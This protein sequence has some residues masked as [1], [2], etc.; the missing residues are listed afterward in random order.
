L[1]NNATSETG[2]G[3]AV[4]LFGT[5]MLIEDCTFRNNSAGA[6]GAITLYQ[7]LVE[8]RRCVFEGNSAR[9]GGG[10]IYVS[11]ASPVIEE[12]LFIANRAST[13][14]G[15]IQFR[16]A[17]LSPVTRCTF[18]GNEAAQGGAMGLVEGSLNVPVLDACL[19]VFQDGGAS[20]FDSSQ[21]SYIIECTN[22]FGNEG[23]D[24]IGDFAFWSTLNGNLS[25]YPLFCDPDQ[26]DYSLAANSPCLP[27]NHP[28]GWNCGLIGALGQ[29]CGPVA[30]T[31]QTW[32][33]VKARYRR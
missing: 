9:W 4:R 29:G 7:G 19:I 1:E 28:A 3:G 33:R 30:L 20:L 17:Y 23:G 14:G 21:G 25:V 15:A 31:P 2:I 10:A 5:T 8:I 13:I 24:W 32:A 18:V 12:C 6:G 22:I 11:Y 27:G 26:G 16:G